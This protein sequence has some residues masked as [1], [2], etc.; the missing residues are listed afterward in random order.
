MGDPRKKHKQFEKPKKV[1]DAER[2]ARDRKTLEE[3]GLKNMREIWRSQTILR[4]KR[5]MARKLLAEGSKDREQRKQE[6]LG[7]LQQLGILNENATLDD[8][9]GLKEK[10]LLERRLQTLALRKGL[11]FTANQARQLVVHGHVGIAGKKVSAPGYLVPKKFE[12]EI[13]MYGK[14]IDL[15][16]HVPEKKDKKKMFEEVNPEEKTI[17]AKE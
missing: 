3:Y 6:L 7:G 17:E 14:P 13:A 9:L 4:D 8:V 16:I 15:S 11:A 10:D 1:W 2:I 12:N 5:R